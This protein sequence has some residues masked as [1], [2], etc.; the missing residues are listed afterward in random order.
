MSS[1][2]F[3]FYWQENLQLQM[4]NVWSLIDCW[5]KQFDNQF[6][7][8]NGGLIYFTLIFKWIMDFT[9]LFDMNSKYDLYSICQCNS[10]LYIDFIMSSLD[11]SEL[12]GIKYNKQWISSVRLLNS[13]VLHMCVSIAIDY[14]Q[15]IHWLHCAF[16]KIYMIDH[17]FHRRIFSTNNCKMLKTCLYEY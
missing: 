14:V 6:S 2:I 15:Q 10:I 16:S 11:Q 1:S 4:I 13:L 8:V 7:V 5:H 3:R 17:H 12:H 9:S